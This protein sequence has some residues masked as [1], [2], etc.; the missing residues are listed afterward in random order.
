[1]SFYAAQVGEVI[2]KISADFFA[3]T[4]ERLRTKLFSALSKIGLRIETFSLRHCVGGSI[5][6]PKRNGK[7]S[8]QPHTMHRQGGSFM[9]CATA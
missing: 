4:T 2:A 1:M 5:I 6:T 8:M 7:A 9:A 3:R